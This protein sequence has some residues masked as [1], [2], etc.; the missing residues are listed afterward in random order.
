V[1][2]P[3]GEGRPNFRDLIAGRGRV[4]RHAGGFLACSPPPHPEPKTASTAV[5]LP[6]GMY[7]AITAGLTDH[8]W[9]VKDIIALMDPATARIE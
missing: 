7:V 2:A 1:V 9:T 4:P 5:C 6:R 8:V 3:D